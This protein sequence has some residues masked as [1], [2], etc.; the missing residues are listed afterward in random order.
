MANPQSTEYMEELTLP[1]LEENE[2]DSTSEI[3]RGQA[4]TNVVSYKSSGFNIK[5]NQKYV[6]HGFYDGEE[7]PASLI[8]YE[9]RLTSDKKSHKRRIRYLKVSLRFEADPRGEPAQDPYLISWEPAGRG[10]V[11][12]YPTP[13]SY[14]DEKR[15][16][17]SASLKKDPVEASY[18]HESTGSRTYDRNDK[19]LCTADPDETQIRGEGRK[20][21]D[22]IQWQ[23]LENKSQELLPDSFNAA[24]V[25]RRAP[26]L[27]FRVIFGASIEV[28]FW[29]DLSL[30][31]NQVKNILP[32]KGSRELSK[33]Y[34][35]AI[36]GNVPA[37]L[38]DKNLKEL[39]DRDGL[40]DFW[41]FHTPEEVNVTRHY[42][43]PRDRT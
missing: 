10:E 12:I 39:V 20:G 24:M 27:N 22:V 2:E 25:V 35:V 40:D 8:V 34:D 19:A 41:G 26:G 6:V 5:I 28:D 42:A 43:P 31:F 7:N 36:Q 15:N 33:V 3:L 17:T 1:L 13:V 4:L 32:F 11:Y 23:L 29:Y 21:P 30:A 38:D 18:Q 16:T 9:I 14:T 37:G